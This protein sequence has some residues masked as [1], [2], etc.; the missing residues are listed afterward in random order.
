[1]RTGDDLAWDYNYER[2]APVPA[3]IRPRLSEPFHELLI[4]TAKTTVFASAAILVE[5]VIRRESTTERPRRLLRRRWKKS[6]D[7]SSNF[8]V[9]TPNSRRNRFLLTGRRGV[10]EIWG[11]N[12]RPWAGDGHENN[13]SKGKPSWE[14]GGMN[15]EK[16]KKEKQRTLREER[17]AWLILAPFWGRWRL[18]EKAAKEEDVRGS[19]WGVWGPVLFPRERGWES[20]LLF[21]YTI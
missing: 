15:V 14:L 20:W 9:K 8:A 18:W 12:P 13:E 2:A 5:T 4:L 6:S 11:R 21:F 1:M 16:R 19:C 10:G 7:S 17:R 3:Y